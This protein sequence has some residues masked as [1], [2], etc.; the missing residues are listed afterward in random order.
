MTDL[1][2][3]PRRTIIG[4]DPGAS[5]GIAV[6]YGS[7]SIDVQKMPV[8]ER[9]LW[10][11]LVE[12]KRLADPEVLVVLEQVQ[13]GGLSREK[14]EGEN[15]V[16]HRMGAKSAFT[17]GRGIGRLEMAVIAAALRVER[18]RPAVWQKALG[19]MTKGDKNVSK[20]RA[21]ELWPTL[22]ITH[23]NADALLI[24]EYGRRYVP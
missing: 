11:L 2:L 3:P 5:G 13:P 20:R 21:Q 1:T 17:F 6:L 8:T 4:I 7:G 15:G 14:A 19:C 24:A 18:V 23:W 16:M 22:K 12:R 10:D 9:D